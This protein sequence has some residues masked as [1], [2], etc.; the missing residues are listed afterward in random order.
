MI[1]NGIDLYQIQFDIEYQELLKYT[2]RL[3]GELEV[4]RIM[5]ITQSV[6]AIISLFLEL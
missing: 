5:A 6:V 4:W 3:E 2:Y 1:L